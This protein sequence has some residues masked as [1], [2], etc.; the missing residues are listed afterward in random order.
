MIKKLIHY[1]LISTVCLSCFGLSAEAQDIQALAKLDQSTIRIGDQTKLHLSV[2]QPLKARVEFPVLADSLAG[3]LLIIGS[4]KQ[5]TIADQNNPDRITVTKT[6]VI[7][8][9]DE[10]NYTIPA[11]EFKAAAGIVKSPEQR[12]M[13]QS[14]KVDTTKAIY[15]IKQP[16]AVS[17]TFVD[18]L[19]D[20]WEWVLFPILMLVAIGAAIYYLRK[21]AAAQ[22]VVV[23]VKPEI[24]A[25]TIALQQL[26]ELRNKKLWQQE[27]V[28]EYYIELSDIIRAYLEKRYHTKTHEK[29]TDEIMLGLVGKEMSA[30]NRELVYQL[31]SGSDLVKFAKDKPLPMENEQRID[32]ALRFVE[33]TAERNV[34]KKGYVEGGVKGG[35]V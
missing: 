9:F 28:K 20:N 16:L 24:P 8:G 35:N 27:Q 4:S 1:I 26:N 3:K 5:D 23:E 32:D 2:S 12:L 33:Q 31:L 18:W 6:L 21:R 11:F 10:G 22:P 34:V 17:Y 19:K 15:D 13:V 29:T 30:Q 14:V 7:T 25:H